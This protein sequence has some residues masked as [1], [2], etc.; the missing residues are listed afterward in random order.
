MPFKYISSVRHNERL[1][2]Y[3]G[4]DCRTCCILLTGCCKVYVGNKFSKL[5]T[6]VE[7]L[8]ML[9]KNLGYLIFYIFN[10][11]SQWP[12]D[13]RRR[14]SAT[15]PLRL[16]VRIPPGEWMF[17][18]CERCVLSGRGLCDE[19]ITRPEESYRLWRVVCDQETSI[20]EEAKARYW[21]VKIQPQWVVTS[22]ERTSLTTQ[23]LL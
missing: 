8:V 11:W 16:W 13:L 7:L 9:I 6:R 17:V 10:C 20:N 18:Y 1:K 12:R 4:S 14:Y 23:L 15:R 2:K 21:A 22:G 19:P 5:D 3:H